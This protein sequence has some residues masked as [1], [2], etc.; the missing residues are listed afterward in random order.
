LY[1]CR[2]RVHPRR[3][4]D[5]SRP[6]DTATFLEVGA[7]FDRY[8]IE[9]VLGAGGM[10]QVYRAFDTRLQR[11]VAVLKHW[12]EARPRSVSAEQARTLS[13]ELGCPAG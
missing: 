5:A 3:W 8:K 9:A 12:G 1:Q 6:C 2:D 11:R 13:R 10:G 4:P 7:N